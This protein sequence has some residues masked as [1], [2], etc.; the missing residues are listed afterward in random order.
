VVA[1]FIPLSQMMQNRL[2]ELDK[3]DSLISRADRV[4]M[5]ISVVVVSYNSREPLRDCL[6]SIE[7]EPWE[8]VTVVDNLSSDGSAEMVSRDFPWVDLI[9]CQRNNGYGAAANL[10]IARCFSKYVL[11]L[12]CDTVLQPGVLHVLSDYLDR[13]PQ[14]AVVG[15][16]LVNP[17]GTCQV[18]CFE[19]PSPLETLLRETN[20]PRL[21]NRPAKFPVAGSFDEA[22]Q[23]AQTVPWVLG[24][25][26]AIRRVAFEAVAGFDESFFMYFE[27]VDLCY[28]LRRS[29]WQTHFL[30]EAFVMHVGGASTKRLRAAMLEQLYKSLCHFYQQHYS[31]M[32]KVQLRFILTYLML[33]NIVRDRFRSYRSARNKDAFDNLWV[34]RSILSNVWSANGWLRR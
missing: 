31:V 6:A 1:G 20:L 12:N 28:R 18:S 32:Q 29:G 34:W 24:A 14:V 33:R 17:D 16:Q 3:K 22:T 23:G 27:E 26:L 19:F 2:S 7:L 5:P 30:P 15:P 10:A 8:K 11:L 21:I 4:A 13:H 25:A 9:L